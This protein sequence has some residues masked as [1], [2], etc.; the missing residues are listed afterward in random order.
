VERGGYYPPYAYHPE[1]SDAIF[2]NPRE[3]EHCSVV[4][5]KKSHKRRECR[6]FA[7]DYIIAKPDRK[8]LSPHAIRD[9]KQCLPVSVCFFLRTNRKRKLR[10]TPTRTEKIAREVPPVLGTYDKKYF[11][12]TACRGFF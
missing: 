11:S 2:G 8:W 3:R 6:L 5:L 7:N 9:P 4:L 12:D 1:A 10:K